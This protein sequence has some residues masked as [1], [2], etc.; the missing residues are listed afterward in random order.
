MPLPFPEYE[1]FDG[2]GL[3]ALVKSKEVSPLELVDAAIARIERRD[4]RLNAVIHRQF[5]KARAQARGALGDG[6]FAGVP[7]LLKDIMAHEQGEP[8]TS[9]SRLFHGRPADHDAE[10][11][12]RYRRAGLIVLGRTNVP[13]LGI[14]AATEPELYGPA[15]NP[16]NPEHTPGGSSGGSAAAVAAGY[17]PMAHGGDGGGSIRIPAAHTGL[18]G[19]KPTR[20]RNPAGPRAGERWGGFVAEHVLTRSVRDSA[21]MLDATHGPDLGAPY[22]VAPPAGPFL[23]ETL[24]PPRKLRIAW[25][26]DALFGDAT[27]PDCVAAVRDAADLARSLGHVVVEARPTFDRQR[28]TDA[29]FTVVAAGT[30]LTLAMAGEARGK[31][32]S[33]TE[34]ERPT[35]MLKL[36]ADKL[37]AGEYAAALDTI[38]RASREVAPFFS[39]Y[40]VFLTPTAARPPALIGAFAL[41]PGERRLVAALAALP[42]RPLLLRALASLAKNALSATP[43]TQLFNMTGQPAVSLPLYWNAAGLPIGTQWVSRFGDEATLFRLAGELERAR[44]WFDKRPPFA[45]ATAD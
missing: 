28:L 23:A 45:L 6:P 19:L 17:V 25:T 20:A 39:Q 33:A 18:V 22:Q 43:N 4:P 42:L 13:E 37:T 5:E 14:Y 35:W 38:H 2:V 32:V 7:F 24:A 27:E 44:P 15:R 34:V 16:W 12:L 21:A 26:A 1:R 29:Y 3:A 41:K 31:P 40:D 8:V 36:I 30:N 9:G 10:L 11:A